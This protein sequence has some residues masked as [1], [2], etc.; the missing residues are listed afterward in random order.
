MLRRPI[1]IAALCLLGGIAGC[2]TTQPPPPRL[3]EGHIAI[4]S[5]SFQPRVE[6]RV[7]VQWTQE[8]AVEDAFRRA[9]AQIKVQEQVSGRLEEMLLHSSYRAA[10]IKNSGPTEIRGNPEYSGLLK[11][12]F[13]GV[14][15]IAVVSIGMVGTKG[16][17]QR[18][19]LEVKLR[20]RV[21]CNEGCTPGERIVQYASRPRVLADWLASGSQLLREEI[22]L[23]FQTLTQYVVEIYFPMSLTSSIPAQ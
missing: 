23:G 15:E 12:G 8:S 20:T 4:V 1:A 2:A 11:H 18:I 3:A 9:I 17:P 6:F 13:D 19:A 10:Y 5:A 14:L 7:L 16:E 22:V 21:F